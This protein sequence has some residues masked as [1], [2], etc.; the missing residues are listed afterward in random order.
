VVHVLGL[1]IA[2]AATTSVAAAAPP[3]EGG[4][5]PYELATAG[6]AWRIATRRGPIRVWAPNGYDPETAAT[7][8]YV[9][10]YYA[11]VDRAWTR[12]RL[13]EQFAASQLNALFVVCGAPEGPKE[14]V[15][16]PSLAELLRVVTRRLPIQSP[17][18]P[19]MAIG[20]S[21]AHHTLESW[22]GEPRLHTIALV[23]AAYGKLWRYRAWLGRSRQ[24]R[25]I[26]VAS[27]TR[28]RTD[29]FHR[30][31]PDT[32]VVEGFPPPEAGTLPE[33]AR[34]AR[35]LYVR[36]TREHME[37]VTDGVAL[38]MTLRALHAPMVLDQPRSTPL[39]RLRD[40]DDDEDPR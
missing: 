14:P 39:I 36:A 25:L 38:P 33:D 28:R 40:P 7:V 21:G 18:G 29:R 30:S 4:P 35:I 1:V 13:P 10:G 26:D 24:R 11:G 12:H 8:V 31:L 2:L 23:D 27:D 5:T 16:W 34:R 15:S 3:A 9:H 32:R 6:D 37:L 19:V 22:L 17:A 20:H